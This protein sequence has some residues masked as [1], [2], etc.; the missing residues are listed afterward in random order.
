MITRQ[1]KDKGSDLLTISLCIV[2]LLLLFVGLPIALY[3]WFF[4]SEKREGAP[5]SCRITK[6]VARVTTKD[7]GDKRRIESYETL[8]ED[9]STPWAGLS[10]EEIYVGVEFF[11]RRLVWT[12]GLGQT[13]QHIIRPCIVKATK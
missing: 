9:S 3:D 8:C 1:F 5:L 11:C 10:T 13:K 6:V 12:S 4:S 2:L 7:S